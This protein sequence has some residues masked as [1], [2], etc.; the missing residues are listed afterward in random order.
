[1]SLF[2][3][4]PARASYLDRIGYHAGL[5]A[6]I[7]CIMAGLILVGNDTTQE[8]IDQ[9]LRDDQ[10]KMLAEV[11][12]PSLYNNNLLDNTIDVPELREMTGSGT[13]YVARLDDHITGYAFTAT[14]E[15]YGGTIKMM[16]GVDSSGKIIGVRVIS[17]S[18][19]PGLGDRIELSKD[20]WILGFSNLSLANTSREQWAVKKDGG[21]IDQFTGATITPRAVVR[22]IV[23]GLDF[24]ET[25]K[26]GPPDE[27]NTQPTAK[28]N[29]GITS[30]GLTS[31]ELNSEL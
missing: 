17:H 21:Q 16:M 29:K 4:T 5:L 7:C 1:M 9:A 13:L 11:L 2:T 12:P 25:F 30:E 31:E 8:R 18:E 27:L 10:L 15:G 22:G 19:T 14:S 6:G 23:Q 20:N 26:S 24:F 3:P 28:T